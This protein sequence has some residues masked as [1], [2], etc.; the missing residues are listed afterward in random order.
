MRG[1]LGLELAARITSGTLI[2]AKNGSTA[3]QFTPGRIGV[4][5]EYHAD[6]VTAGSVALLLQISLPLLLYSQTPRAGVD[7]ATLERQQAAEKSVLTL[8]G[9]TNATG[10]PQID[11]LQHVF[12]PFF[13]KHFGL[14]EDAVKI[15]VRKRGYFPK[16]GGEVVTTVKP[17]AQGDKLKSLKLVERGKV[18]RICGIAHYSRLPTA[19][20]Q[21][22][23]A[24]AM[25]VLVKAGY[26][27]ASQEGTLE[28]VKV[29]IV[30]CREPNNVA[31]AAGSGIVLW[32]ELECGGIIGG[33]AVGK[34]GIAAKDVGAEAAEMLVKGLE[35]G[36]CV[37]EWL[38]DQIIIFMTLADGVS[39]VNCGKAELELHTR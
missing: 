3:I 6:S 28:E 23:I 14:T 8:L 37:D 9:G 15:E 34:K 31:V 35:N 29:E 4:P 5:G 24:G 10:A 11:Y 30:D 17:L 26:G 22:M 36:G 39:E 19:I 27:R 38:Q 2:G 33:S 32:A 25:K 13:S 12:L 20:G 18:K 21:D 7:E 1:S 16:G